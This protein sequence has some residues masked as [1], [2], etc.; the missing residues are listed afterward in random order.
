MDEAEAA[1][2][3]RVSVAALRRYEAGEVR[4][5][6]LRLL[7]FASHLDAPLSALFAGASRETARRVVDHVRRMGQGED[8][9][10]PDQRELLAFLHAFLGIADD[11]KRARMV[12]ALAIAGD[13]D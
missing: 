6:A 12:E 1:A 9:V 4:L 2:A 10:H 13:G 8:A 5:T 11:A 3:L 7:Q